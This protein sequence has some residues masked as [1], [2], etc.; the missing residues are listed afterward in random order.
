[1]PSEEQLRLSKDHPEMQ[2]R[3]GLATM[4]MQVLRMLERAQR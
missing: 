1:M 4:Q 3:E 2:L